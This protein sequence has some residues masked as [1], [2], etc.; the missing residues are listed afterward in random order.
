MAQHKP[1]DFCLVC[2]AQVGGPRSGPGVGDPAGSWKVGSTLGSRTYA[3]MT[4][5]V[6]FFKRLQMNSN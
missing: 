4:I 3:V 6:V 5:E 2:L 1:I